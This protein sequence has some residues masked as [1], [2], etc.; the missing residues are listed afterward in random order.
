MDLLTALSVVLLMIF[1]HEIV[2]LI[3]AYFLK[4]RIEAFL[5]SYFG[6]M[7]YLVDE[8]LVYSSFKIVTISLLPLALSLVILL[9][10]S[11]G[12]ILFSVSNIGGSVGDVYMVIKLLRKDPSERLRWSKNLKKK[13]A[14][15]AIYVK[16]LE[17]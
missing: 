4:V 6:I 14:R 13:L 5:V 7:F 2:H 9:S 15:R 3:T 10:Q 8:D 1:L 12:T 11:S 17:Y 16:K